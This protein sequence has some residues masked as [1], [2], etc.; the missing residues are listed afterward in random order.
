[1]DGPTVWAVDASGVL[2]YV[3][4][5]TFSLEEFGDAL[6]VL[7]DGV[8]DCPDPAGMAHTLIRMALSACHDYVDAYRV[9]IAKTS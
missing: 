9:G 8:D 7:A 2:G 5:P 4:D 1:M 3:V 6:D